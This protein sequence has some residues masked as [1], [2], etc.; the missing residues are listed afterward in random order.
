MAVTADHGVLDIPEHAAE[1][2]GRGS[3]ATSDDFTALRRTFREFQEAEGDPVDLADSL[4]N[5]LESLPFVADAMSVVE[6]TTPPP[7]DSFATLMRNS[8]HPDRWL[9]GF[10]SAGSGVVFRFEEGYYP[11][12]SSRGTGHGTPY[13]YDRHVPLVFFGA[14]IEAGVS[15]DPVRSVDIAPTLAALA[16][17]SVPDDLDGRALFR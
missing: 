4:A 15:N 2:G 3:R 16:G 12:A 10:G 8:Y 17:I 1:E 13:Y 6:L 7:A 14:G 5:R 9:G 11:D